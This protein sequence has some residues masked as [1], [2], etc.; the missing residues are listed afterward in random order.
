MYTNTYV[1]WNWW[2][3]SGDLGGELAIDVLVGSDHYWEVATGRVIWGVDQWLLRLSL[4]G[5]CLKG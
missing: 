4:G 2:V 5:Y 1:D 3:D